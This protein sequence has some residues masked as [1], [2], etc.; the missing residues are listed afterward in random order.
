MSKNKII[1]EYINQIK[2]SMP[3]TCI[4]KQAEP[5]IRGYNCIYMSIPKLETDKI[6][7]S[8]LNRETTPNCFCCW[9]KRRPY[10]IYN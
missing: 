5:I 6:I 4:H 3:G 10:P 1:A 7:C 8:Y 9:A 2:E